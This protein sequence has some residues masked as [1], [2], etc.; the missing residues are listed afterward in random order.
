MRMMRMTYAALAVTAIAVLN[1]GCG[2]AV[3]N[4]GYSLKPGKVKI[5]NYETGKTE[6][7][8]KVIKTDEAWKKLLTPEE[9]KITRFKATEPACSGIYDKNKEKGLYKCICCGIDMFVSDNKFES[10]TGWPSFYKPVSELNIL[11]EEDTSF[12]MV[13]I[14]LLCARCGAHLGHVFD[15]G[16]KPTGKRY[17]IN[18]ASLKFIKK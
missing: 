11:Y 15:D 6:E 10:G 1:A 7:V 16:P 2:G 8:D 17:C 12:G 18:S 13:R 5:Y 9:F 14:E 4:K 3:D